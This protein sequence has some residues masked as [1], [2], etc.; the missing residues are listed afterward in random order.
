MSDHEYGTLVI[1]LLALTACG[2][3]PAGPSYPARD[4]T[5]VV[6]T[7]ASAFL[8]ASIVV[9]VGDT[10]AFRFG[11][12]AHNVI[13]D[14]AP[15]VPADVGGENANRTV[16]RAFDT[17]GTYRYQCHLHAGMAGTVTVERPALSTFVLHDANGLTPPAHIQHY[18]ID[19]G[20]LDV[21]ALDDTLWLE[22]GAHYRQRANLEV[23][24]N[25]VFSANVRWFDRGSFAWS[26]D[27][28]LGTSEY[29]E[30]RRLRGVR[31]V[32]G[33][34]WVDQDL[35]GN[36]TVDRYALVRAASR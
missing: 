4:V 20:R 28:L 9:S 31:D 32:G 11:A 1:A 29:L 26:G 24:L 3:D 15:G 6:A 12:T 13:F 16:I 27:T 14:A 35:V 33:V 30:G 10:V 5:A 25:D 8:P 34:L 7:S 2:S 22:A 19:A 21:Y 17:A 36:G 23:R 18:D